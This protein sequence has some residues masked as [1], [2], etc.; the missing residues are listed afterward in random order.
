MET[1]RNMENRGKIVHR[2][3]LPAIRRRHRSIALCSGCFDILQSGHAVFFEQCKQLAETLVVVVGSDR[4]IARQ[5]GPLRPINPQSNRMYLVAAMSQVDYVILGDDELKAG[6]IDY[7]DIARSLKP[8]ILVVND[9]DS[10][11]E[12]KRRLCEQLGITLETVARTVPDFLRP[13]SSTEI[14]GKQAARNGKRRRVVLVSGFFDML[15][16]GHIEFLE[17]AASLGELYVNV[18]SDKNHELVR[19]TPSL[20]SESERVRMV[21]SLKCVKKAF[22][23]SGVGKLDFVSAFDEVRPD[24]FAVNIDGHSRDKES[25]CRKH[26]I[27]YRLLG[28]APL[29]G[30]DACAD[31]SGRTADPL[32]VPYRLAI[33]GG[34]IDQPWVSCICPGSMV[35]A[36]LEPV[37][38]FARRCGMAT[39]TRQTARRIWGERIPS[40]DPQKVARILFGA[41]NPPGT[42]Q[43]SGSQDAIGLVYPGINRLYYDGDYWPAE[44]T[45]LIDS[46]TAAWL[47]E[48]I[49]LIPVSPRPDGYDPLIVKNLEK[50]WVELLGRSGEECWRA[51]RQHDIVLLGESLNDTL[52]A[53]RKL[54]PNTVPDHIMEQVSAFDSCYGRSL[55]GCGGG[56]VI[57][58]AD[59]PIDGSVRIKVKN[60]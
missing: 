32:R 16:A 36:R 34:W 1:G 4:A 14:A 50:K 27:E 37:C 56:Y 24:I 30:N 2:D 25:V 41:E 54:L 21:S 40:G 38:E 44:I 18:G 10:G 39:S 31:S 33:A 29:P 3:D 23:S 51:I 15:G 20:F 43:I 22:V 47:E 59:E 55:S 35:V 28:N 8:D 60:V 42:R 7:F 53:W 48:S 6:K 12:E 58:A 45:S 49:Q 52:L 19:E 46:E 13:T 9:D 5:K 57:V 11:L 17:Q 26:G